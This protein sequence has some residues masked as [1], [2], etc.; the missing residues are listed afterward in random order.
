MIV[1]DSKKKFVTLYKEICDDNY[2]SNQIGIIQ[3]KIGIEM[4][5]INTDA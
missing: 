1:L 3:K 5:S 4:K 2:F